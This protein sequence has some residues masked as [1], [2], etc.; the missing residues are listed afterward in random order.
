MYKK[1]YERDVAYRSWWQGAYNRF[2][3][4]IGARNALASKKTERVEKWIDF[5]DPITI[6]E[7]QKTKKD[8]N[9]EHQ[10]QQ[11]WFYNMFHNDK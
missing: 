11:M 3:V 2:A 10:K 8:N 9:V 5:I 4:E 1:A 6:I 7:K